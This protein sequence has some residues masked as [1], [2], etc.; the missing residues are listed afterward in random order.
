MAAKKST[1]VAGAGVVAAGAVVGTWFLGIGPTLSAAADLRAQTE[2]TEQQNAVLQAKLVTLQQDFAKLPQYKADLAD[3]QVGIP[4]DLELGPY[5][6]Q[7]DAFAAAHG[8]TV[9]EVTPQAPQSIGT[10]AAASAPT[11]GGSAT[12][13]ATAAPS[14]TTTEAPAADGEATDSSGATADTTAAGGEGTAAVPAGLADLIA[15]PVSFTVL[16]SFPGA[17]SFLHDVQESSSRLMLVSGITGLGQG[18]EEASGGRPATHRGDIELA[19]SGFLYVLPG[20]ASSTEPD[21]GADTGLPQGDV[22]GDPVA[23]N[24]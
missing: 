22:G 10:A 12:D 13:G 5:L 11:S 14:D 9:I 15:V 21:D 1:W 4:T 6:D 18:D 23:P 7:L 8:V 19:V 16:G 20:E 2:S 24:S 3:L 17:V